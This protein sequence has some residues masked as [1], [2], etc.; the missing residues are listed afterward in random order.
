MKN[1]LKQNWFRISLLSIL[2]IS[3]VGA[4]Y[5]YEW[6]PDQIRKNCYDIAVMIGGVNFDKNYNSCLLDNGLMK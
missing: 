3:I 1:F 2:V 5:W 4:F 6:R